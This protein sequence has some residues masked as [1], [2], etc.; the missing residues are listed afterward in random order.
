[1]PSRYIHKKISKTFINNSCEKTNRAID[2]PV[3]ILGKKHR[4]LFHDPISALIVGF[5]CDGVEGVASALLHLAT[6]YYCSKYPII[7]KALS[8]L[9]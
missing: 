9:L 5:V 4:I 6:D 3:K 8:Y 1:M 2:Y 7:K